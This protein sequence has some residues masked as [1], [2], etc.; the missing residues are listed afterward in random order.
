M[1]IDNPFDNESKMAEVDWLWEFMSCNPQLS[2][3]TP[4]ATS[5]SR[6]VGF[7]K[8]KLNQLFSVYKS[9]FEEYKFSAKQLWNMGETGITNVQ[10][11]GK[12]IA[13]KGK[14]QVSKMTSGE[15]GTTVTVVCAMSASG[16]YVPPLFIFPRK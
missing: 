5:V 2:I 10:K 8:P 9:L 15:R 11:L 7:N 16:A 13:I 3:W 1:E 4:Q 6:P 14:Q 12:V